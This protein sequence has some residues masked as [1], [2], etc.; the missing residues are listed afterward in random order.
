[1]DDDP[2]I[3]MIKK[4]IERY[5]LVCCV[6]IEDEN[7]HLILSELVNMADQR[8]TKMSKGFLVRGLLDSI[9]QLRTPIRWCMCANPADP[10]KVLTSG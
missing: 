8:F 4:L 3:E 7:D 10:S 5:P 6:P 2:V 1:V 9:N